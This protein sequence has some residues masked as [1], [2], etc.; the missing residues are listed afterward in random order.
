MI[1]LPFC[2]SWAVWLREV[3]VS[4]LHPKDTQNQ[5]LGASL[6]PLLSPFLA[7][8][9]PP[10]PVLLVLPLQRVELLASIATTTITSHYSGWYSAKESAWMQEM[11]APSLDQEVPLKK[12]MT[13]WSSIVAWRI[14]WTKQPGR[15]QSIELQ[16]V[17]HNWSDLACMQIP[18][19]HTHMCTR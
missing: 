5:G 17:G 9:L 16:R 11:W 8:L 19:T 2:K 14:P 18:H 10:V 15:L 13:T 1:S 7:L 6:P 4:G 3:K 12:E